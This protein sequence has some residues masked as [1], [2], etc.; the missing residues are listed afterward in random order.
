MSG[1][2]LLADDSI[3]IQKVVELTFA[4]TEH[5]V[6][7]VGGGRDLLQRLPEIK[8][9][10]VLC[11]VVMPD[12]NGYE[13][14]QILKSDPNTLHIPVVLLTGT[15]EPFDRDRAQ[16]AGCDAI[17]TKPFE[18]RE[19][20]GVVEDLL[21][22]VQTIAAPP[23]P[24]EYG[25]PGEQGIPDGVPSLDFSTSGFDRMV[26]QVPPAP[27]IPEDGIDLTAS[28]LGD[29]HPSQPISAPPELAEPEVPTAVEAPSFAFGG[30]EPQAFGEAL[31][32]GAPASMPPL[33]SAT[34]AVATE[35]PAPSE[36]FL[37]EE[38][39]SEPAR[40]LFALEPAPVPET[41]QAFAPDPVIEPEPEI[42]SAPVFAPEVVAVPPLG[43]AMDEGPA[44]R[45]NA[46]SAEPAHSEA[47]AGAVAA[48]AAPTAAAA[49]SHE[50][51]EHIARRVVELIPQPPPA[52][53]PL[54]AADLLT[55]EH[56]E[57]IARRA[58]ELV[59]VPPA[60]PT[61]AELFTDEHVERVARRAIEL[62]PPPPAPPTAAEL[63]TEEHVERVAKRAAELVPVPPAPPTV[64]ELLTEEHVERVAKRAAELIPPPAA[65]AP[66]E[67][68]SDEQIER[69]ARRVVELAA[70]QL[71]RI[72][73]EVIPDLAEMLVRKRIAELEKAAEEES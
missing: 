39:R 65:P 51:M 61:A 67:P 70:P 47:A 49:L 13:V 45:F 37:V 25:G 15:F 66:P 6:F 60:P 58:A 46:A 11:D 34:P 57:R 73:W 28:S 52:P 8:P 26:P 42:E 44:Q 54:T 30:E 2:L 32:F 53:A 12:M 72:A 69:I 43:A 19:L 68:L 59:P 22:R 63:L 24:A 5:K 23:A 10:I 50:A 1:T 38:A 21:G 55:D 40:D 33:G 36:P 3:T 17:V 7:A 64:A 35:P 18:A 48:M 20:I 4:E 27:P 71:E 41:A 29:S 31:Q 14:C 62:V 16:A 56:V 9:D